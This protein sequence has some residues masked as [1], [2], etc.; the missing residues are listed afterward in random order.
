M[1]NFLVIYLRTIICLIFDNYNI[2][3]PQIK[4]TI[5]HYEKKIIIIFFIVCLYDKCISMSGGNQ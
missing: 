5:N 2:F 3:A 1:V 4:P